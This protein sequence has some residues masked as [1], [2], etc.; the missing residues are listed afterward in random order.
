MR[1][2]SL[3]VLAAIFFAACAHYPVNEKLD[4]AD[5]KKGYRYS[6]LTLPRED[7]TFVVLTFSGGG[8][9]AAGFAYGVLREMEKKTLP[10]GS[11][12]LDHIDVI[13]SVSGG[14]F[15]SMYYGL[16]GR[17]GLDGFKTEFL[18]KNIE[19]MLFK[20]AVTNIFRLLSPKFS[21]IDLAAELYDREVFGNK[22]YADLLA[23]QAA[24]KRPYIVANATELDLGSRFEWTQ[25]QFDPICSDLSKVHVARAV[26]AS[27]AFPVLLNPM[28]L[29]S[30]QGTCEFRTPGWVPL[31]MG[32]L[33]INASR[34]RSAIELTAYL[35][36]QRA[37]LHLM[38]GGISDNIGLRGTLHA[39]S[40]TDTFQ[41]DDPE[42]KRTGYTLQ[43]PINRR[44]IKRLLVIVVN[45]ATSNNLKID[46]EEKNPKLAQI[47]GTIS[48]APMANFSF[49]TV[50]MLKG[51][52]DMIS[53][54][55]QLP[56]DCVAAVKG[57]CP[58]ATLPGANEPAVSFYPVVLGFTSVTDPAFQKQLN[59]IGTNFALK[60]GQLELLE[61]AAKDLL[62]GSD[63]YQRFLKDVGAR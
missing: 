20:A 33:E 54:R 59:D 47:L 23:V 44:E 62:D 32:D 18:D 41:M 46:K 60:P 52:V 10:D 15:M 39:L 56:A 1:H 25:D 51:T 6:N 38:D 5:I 35:N 37:F 42:R 43:G 7:G 4:R 31:A 12:L 40:S 24:N 48:F 17:E 45:A 49:D 36:P 21:R 53:L 63:A 61:R 58:N 55:Q 11:N 3:L 13:S 19:G 9:R 16:H 26:A 30:Y 27:S 50:Q 28:Q 22:T 8:S 14:S 29:K 57:Q 34:H 2:R